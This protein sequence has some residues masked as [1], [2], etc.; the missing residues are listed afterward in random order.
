[1]QDDQDIG[2]ADYDRLV[3]YGSLPKDK[4]LLLVR[5]QAQALELVRLNAQSAKDSFLRPAIMDA[6][7]DARKEE[8][9]LRSAR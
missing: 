1:M 6:L 4:L 8:K 3:E 9:S 2:F 7:D 5:C